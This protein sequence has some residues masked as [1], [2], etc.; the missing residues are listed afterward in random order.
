MIDIV[1]N[2]TVLEMSFKEKEMRED[3]FKAISVFLVE[4]LVREGFV[5]G[6]IDSQAL[7]KMKS[8]A[9]YEVFNFFMLSAFLEGRIVPDIVFNEESKSIKIGVKTNT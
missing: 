5:G 1:K 6:K 9:K 8:Y 4:R 2:E 7:D 3:F